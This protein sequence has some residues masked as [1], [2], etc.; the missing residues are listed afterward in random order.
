MKIAFALIPEKGHI[1]P[2][3]G[4][5]QALVD[6]G[7]QVVVGAPGDI[8]DQIARAGLVFRPDLV[9]ASADDR[10]TRGPELVEL[11]QDPQRLS[12]W[13]EQLLLGGIADQVPRIR[14]WLQRERADVAVVDPL[15]Y[16]AAIAA[17]QCGL[18]W[19]S[20][21]NSLNPVVPNDLHSALLGTLRRISLKRSQL[22]RD[23]G[24][25][26][27]FSSADVLSPYLTVAFATEALV[28][29]SPPGVTLVGPSFP[30]RDRGDEVEMRPLTAD[31]P[32][33]Y[34]SFGSQLSHWPQLFERLLDAGRRVGA[35]LVFSMGDL[36]G[37]SRWATLIPDCDV[38]SYAPQ[39]EVLRQASVFVSHGGANSVM[40]A[41]ACGVPMLLS[42]M[43]NDQFHQA[44]F[45]E[46]AGIGCVEDL[47]NT[48]VG[49]IAE[50]L[51]YLLTN[52]GVRQAMAR[53]AE[54]YRVNGSQE[55]ARLIARLGHA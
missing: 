49:C 3:I 35:H 54:T 37:E 23:H 30:L 17:H 53:V 34:A 28:G 50:R 52:D 48:P 45:V 38:Y 43:C 15:Y 31:R 20:V 32:V 16:P 11:I 18:P 26:P 29:E 13:I 40:E 51:G 42:P 19:A 14:D 47:P 12:G 41:V 27:A 6:M 25:D 9:A 10:V 5:A 21:S 7:H 8:S 24:L 39:L 2:Y 1:N 44:Y 55:T 46:Q 33:V 4:P 36:A 22:F